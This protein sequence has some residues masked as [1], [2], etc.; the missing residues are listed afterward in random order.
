MYDVLLK[1]KKNPTIQDIKNAIDNPE[2]KIDL[3]EEEVDFLK[4]YAENRVSY[5]EKSLLKEEYRIVRRLLDK[6]FYQF[7]MLQEYT[8]FDLTTKIN[9]LILYRDEHR[10]NKKS[11]QKLGEE[12]SEQNRNDWTRRD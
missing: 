11:I 6:I 4:V 9:N 8:D 12:L 5:T 7:V 3:S 1:D 10:E 2:V